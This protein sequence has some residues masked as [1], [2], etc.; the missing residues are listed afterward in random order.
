MLFNCTFKRT[1][2]INVYTFPSAGIDDEGTI[3]KIAPEEKIISQ[4]RNDKN[5]FLF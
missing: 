3:I 4:F 2:L 1:C 5:E